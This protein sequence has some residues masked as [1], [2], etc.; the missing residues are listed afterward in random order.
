MDGS[1]LK[2]SD[3]AFVI[4]IHDRLVRDFPVTPYS[5]WCRWVHNQSFSPL[6]KWSRILSW[7]LSPSEYSNPT[8]F[9][10]DYQLRS[11]LSK[12]STEEVS[13]ENGML[14]AHRK[15][16]DSEQQCRH[17]NDQ[18][19]TRIRP[20][21]QNQLLEL[22][23]KIVADCLGDVKEFFDIFDDHWLAP[24]PDNPSV[25]FDGESRDVSLNPPGLNFGPGVSVSERGSSLRSHIEKLELATV[26]SNCWA[27]IKPIIAAMGLDV[28]PTL[29]GGS[30]L[31]FVPKKSWRDEGN[32]LRT[33]HEHAVSEADRF[34]HE[35]KVENLLRY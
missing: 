31:T 11:L 22:A 10:A 17:V 27:F 25:S 28:R 12:F 20:S 1:K 29:V 13:D 6:E 34:L 5:Q 35:E 8:L 3:V 33:E 9:A 4:N 19:S 16:L 23:K 21:G 7:D 2:Q 32:L 26:T 24:L 14:K 30:K 15:F 18:L